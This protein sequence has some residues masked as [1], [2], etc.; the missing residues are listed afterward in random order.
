MAGLF[1]LHLIELQTR[2]PHTCNQNS[3]TICFFKQIVKLCHDVYDF[4][5]FSS[6]EM[7]KINKFLILLQ[8]QYICL[9]SRFA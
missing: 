5:H 9:F 2:F 4:T 8:F 6:L 7:V 1:Y 3:L